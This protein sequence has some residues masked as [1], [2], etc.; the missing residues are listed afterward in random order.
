MVRYIDIESISKLIN[1]SLK[2][3]IQN[4]AEENNFKT[5]LLN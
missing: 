5:E 3:K 2:D 1:Q 4:E